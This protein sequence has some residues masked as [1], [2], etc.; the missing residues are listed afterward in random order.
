MNKSSFE[1]RLNPLQLYIL[2]WGA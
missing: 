1:K 2:A